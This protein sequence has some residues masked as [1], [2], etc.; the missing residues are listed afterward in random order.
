MAVSKKNIIIE[1]LSGKIG[2]LVFRR[3]KTDGKVFVAVPPSPHR[4]A[5]TGEKKR[6]NDKFKRAV[7]YG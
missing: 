7:L 6:M 5:P 4:T 3:R 1:G 2:N